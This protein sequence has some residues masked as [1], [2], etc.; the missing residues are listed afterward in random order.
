MAGAGTGRM[1]RSARR[2]VMVSSPSVTRVRDF[3]CAK[4]APAV[5]TGRSQRSPARGAIQAA[6]SISPNVATNKRFTT[7]PPRLFGKLHGIA[8]LL[9]AE[10][11]QSAEDRSAGNYYSENTLRTC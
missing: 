6:N 7:L 8:D 1:G 2:A 4:A 3:F 5:S 9:P 11:K 10:R